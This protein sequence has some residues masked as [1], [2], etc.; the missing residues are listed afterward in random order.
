MTKPPP[1][2]P[3]IDENNVLHDPDAAGLIAALDRHNLRH[4]TI[5]FH[6]DRIGHFAQR[7]LE[8]GMSPADTLIVILNVDDDLGGLLGRALMPGTDWGPIR[9]RGETPYARGLAGRAGVQELLDAAGGTGGDQLRA[10]TGTAVLVM[11]RGIVGVFAL[12][13]VLA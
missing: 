4:H 13:E 10:I 6:A 2:L 9:A 12:S 11:D 1:D 8:R 3:Y 5:E 7:A